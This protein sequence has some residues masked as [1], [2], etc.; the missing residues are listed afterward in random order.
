MSKGHIIT[1]EHKKGI[2]EFMNEERDKWVVIASCS[3]SRKK[4]CYN[5]FFYLKYMVEE[6]GVTRA[7]FKSLDKAIEEYNK[8]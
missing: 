8:I 1:E 7:K 3:S 5:A 6:K 4:L 2:I